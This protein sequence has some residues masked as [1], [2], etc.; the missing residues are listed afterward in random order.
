[1]IQE[2]PMEL[3]DF[4]RTQLLIFAISVIV[5]SISL[6]IADYKTNGWLK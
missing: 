4:R 2:I 5:V 1:M 3:T 6:L